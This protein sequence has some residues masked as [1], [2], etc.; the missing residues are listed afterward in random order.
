[1]VELGAIVVVSN[2]VDVVLALDVDTEEVDERHLGNAEER[3]VDDRAVEA[4]RCPGRAGDHR[5][6]PAEGL[7]A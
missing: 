7:A 2:L 6:D 1:M 5:V 4:G 3:G